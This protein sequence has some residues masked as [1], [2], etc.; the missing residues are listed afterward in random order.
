MV[1]DDRLISLRRT[2]ATLSAA[3]DDDRGER[4]KRRFY[5]YQ[6]FSQTIPIYLVVEMDLSKEYCKSLD[7]THE[8][9]MG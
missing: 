2:E 3:G 7:H 5:L 9:H 1:R 6:T 4:L 8:A